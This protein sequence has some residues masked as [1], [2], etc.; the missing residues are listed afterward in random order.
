[1]KLR[2]KVLLISSSL[3]WAVILAG[4]VVANLPETKANPVLPT[5]AAVQAPSVPNLDELAILVN[6]DRTDAGLLPLTR[7]PDLDASA[8]DKCNDMVAG[9]YWGH[10]NS[11]GLH[12]YE[13]IKR[14]QVSSTRGENLAFGYTTADSTNNGWLSSPPHKAALLNSKYSEVGYALCDIEG[15]PNSVVQHFSN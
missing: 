11:S 4:V 8:T 10:V 7:D 1:M 6:K 14:H 2:T 13:Y 15:Y 3:V 12:G 9:K 5:V